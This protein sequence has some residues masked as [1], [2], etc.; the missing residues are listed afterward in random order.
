MGDTRRANRDWAVC[1]EDDGRA[2][3]DGAQLAVLMD[4][5][6]RAAIPQPF[7]AMREPDADGPGGAADRQADSEA[8]SVADTESEV[9][10]R[11][12]S[13]REAVKPKT[14][15]PVT[16]R[17]WE[18][19]SALRTGRA[20]TTRACDRGSNPSAPSGARKGSRRSRPIKAAAVVPSRKAGTGAA[21]PLL[22]PADL[23]EWRARLE[24]ELG[25]ALP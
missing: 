22:S 6:R 9:K 17:G 14:S 2:S 19:R 24:R 4:N 1:G 5:P 15:G 21:R 20:A 11:A 23:A 25:R 8:D 10:G 7:S 3:F 18:G 16:V 12:V 13:R